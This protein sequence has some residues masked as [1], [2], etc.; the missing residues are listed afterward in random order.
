MKV[1]SEY[2]NKVFDSFKLV[3]ITLIGFSNSTGFDIARIR[4]IRQNRKVDIEEESR[5]LCSL[6][7]FYPLQYQQIIEIVGEM[8]ES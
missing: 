8:P 2:I 5:I 1:S 4:R 3:G 6:R 7:K